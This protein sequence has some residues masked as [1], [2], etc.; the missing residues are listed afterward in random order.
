MGWLV[1]ESSMSC[2]GSAIHLWPGTATIIEG[3][4]QGWEQTVHSTM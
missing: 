2:A 3:T 4:S 1:W